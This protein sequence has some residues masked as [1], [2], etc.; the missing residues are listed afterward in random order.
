LLLRGG[1]IH[2]DQRAEHLEI[3]DERIHL[4]QVLGSPSKSRTC[5]LGQRVAKSPALSGSAWAFRSSLAL[6]IWSFV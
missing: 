4:G 5:A 2:I 1:R 3:G 6:A